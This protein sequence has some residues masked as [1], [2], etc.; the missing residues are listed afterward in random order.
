MDVVVAYYQNWGIGFKGTQ[1]LVIPEDRKHFQELTEGGTVIVGRRTLEDFPN[2][3]PLKNRK[4]I[5]MTHQDIE[6]EGATVAHSA[7]EVMEMV[8]D[9]PK[10][11]VI[12]GASVYDALLP[13]CEKVYITKIYARPECDVFFK[14]LDEN[15][16]WSF[17]SESELMTSSTGVQYRYYV[18]EKYY[19]NNVIKKI[20]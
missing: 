13:F 8:K 6:I 14:N 19:I 3:K 9:Q 20:K 5:V 7:Q 1:P 12:G 10:V 17:E 4:T 2:G 15:F 18:Y 16:E 11:F